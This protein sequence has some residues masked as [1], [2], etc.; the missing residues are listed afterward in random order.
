MALRLRCPRCGTGGILDGWFELKKSCGRCSLSLRDAPEDDEWFGGY[1][2]NLI[3]SESLM[4][5]VVL[6]YVWW[7][8]P[9]VQWTRVEVLGI[10]L[11]IVLP[12]VTYPYAKALWVA[13]EFVFA[14]RALTQSG[15]RS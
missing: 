2:M 4:I 7:T 1:F 13:V 6:A 3:A 11:T 10:V 15:R 9:T 12:V 5:V 8:W 14:E